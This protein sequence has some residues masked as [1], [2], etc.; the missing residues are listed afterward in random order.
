V[1]KPVNI[2]SS[3]APGT[4]AEA[5]SFRTLHWRAGERRKLLVVGDVLATVLAVLASLRVWAFVARQ[6][7]TEKYLLRQWHWYIILPALWLLLASVNDYYNLR[8]TARLETSFIYLARITVQVL[9]VYLAIFFFSN[10][11]SLP[12][13]F[14]VYYAVISLVLISLWRSARVLLIRVFGHRRRAII[15]GAGSAVES[16]WHTMMEEAHADY[17]VVGC[18]S[19]TDG[20]RPANPALKLLGGSYDLVDVVRRQ[21]ISEVVVAYGDE[22]PPDLF[23]QVISCYTR[24]VVVVPMPDLFEQITGRVPIEHVDER[25]WALVL[26]LEGY[27]LSFHLY[28]L[29]KR[30]MDVLVALVGLILFL[31][32]APIIALLIKA[33]SRG[34]VLYRQERVGRGGSIFHVFKFRS[35]VVH[36]EQGT[37][38]QW[39]QSRDPR[40]TPVGAL[41][42]KTRLDEVPQL[43]NIL[44]GDMSFVG[45]RPERPAF[46]DM[47]SKEIPFYRARLVIKPGL[48]GWAQV[49]FR[50]GNT[51]EDQL[52]KLQYDLY[53]IRHQS[54]LLDLLIIGKT[55]GTVVSMKGM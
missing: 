36:A 18:V 20:W 33:T 31:P 14:I 11:T 27:R 50:Y 45:P 9:V 24:G 34:P 54:I 4:A 16:M 44:K 47:L 21:G 30:A 12:R 46:V 42:R 53:Y 51:T 19:S 23:Q 49:R 38:P 52:R 26:P 17:D 5:T 43:L 48:T 2:A 35:M 41:L 15:V 1:S 3:A 28:L 7:F 8:I 10:R 13:L 25:L 29:V 55:F 22:A 37:G 39:A 40:V 32:F 6:P